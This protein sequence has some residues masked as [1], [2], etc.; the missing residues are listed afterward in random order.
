MF[1]YAIL[2]SKYIFYKYGVI[3]FLCQNSLCNLD[4][5]RFVIVWPKQAQKIW[6]QLCGYII[7]QTI[8]RRAKSRHTRYCICV[9]LFTCQMSVVPWG[10]AKKLKDKSNG[11][12]REQTKQKFKKIKKTIAKTLRLCYNIKR[13]VAGG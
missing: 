6:R 7:K 3:F 9:K 13:A 10:A 4:K 8:F 12:Q 11:R 1:I 2:Q 5:N